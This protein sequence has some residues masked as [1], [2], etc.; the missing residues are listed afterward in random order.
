MNSIMLISFWGRFIA[1]RVRFDRNDRIIKIVHKLRNPMC[2]FLIFIAVV[3]MAFRYNHRY[4]ANDLLN[5][6]M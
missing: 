4:N 3:T 6:I 5:V 2:A 1:L